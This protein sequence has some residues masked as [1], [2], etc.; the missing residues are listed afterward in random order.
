MRMMAVDPGKCTGWGFLDWLPGEMPTFR[1]GEMSHDQF[2]DW[3]GFPVLHDFRQVPFLHYYGID[4][5]VAEGFKITQR[6]AQTN[7]SDTEL[8]SVK[9]LGML[10]WICR[11]QERP[12]TR[13]MPA[14]KTFDKDGAKIKRLGW[15]APSP[16][17]KGEAGHRRDAARH[18]VKWGVDH[19]IIPLE[20]LL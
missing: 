12:F 4:H 18:A 3:V 8:W 19:R 9:Q 10:E 11:W 5:V 16:G 6:T 1:G 2:M 15:W 14:A 20:A 13:Q 17:V 7:P